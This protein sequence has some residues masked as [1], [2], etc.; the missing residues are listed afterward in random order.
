MAWLCYFFQNF[1]LELFVEFSYSFSWN[2]FLESMTIKKF[3]GISYG[4]YRKWKRLE[5]IALSAVSQIHIFIGGRF[6]HF[7]Q[8]IWALASLK[9]DN[10]IEITH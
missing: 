6:N 5:A 7:I 2:F 9:P 10:N 8:I 4:Q 3:G 1:I